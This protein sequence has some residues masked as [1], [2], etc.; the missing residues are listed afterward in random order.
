M[1]DSRGE[2]V[3]DHERANQIRSRRLASFAA[4]IGAISAAILC[5]GRNAE[6]STT[7]TVDTTADVFVV[8]GSC[9]LREAISAANSDSAVDSC[10]A[11]GGA[12]T[13]VLPAGVYALGIPGPNEDANASGDL[14][15]T[16]DLTISGSGAGTTIIDGAHLDRVVHVV[17]QAAE[18]IVEISD[19]TI[20]GGLAPVQGLLSRG[21]GILNSGTLTVTGCAVRGNSGAALDTFGGGIYNDGMLLLNNS[22]VSANVIQG[23]GGSGVYNTGTGAI[24]NSTVSGNVTGAFGGGVGNVGMISIENTTISGNTAF[25]G[26]G[27]YNY[28]SGRLT[29]SSSTVTR[30][31]ALF[32]GGVSNAGDSFIVKD[33]IIAMNIAEGSGADCSLSTPMSSLGH[34]LDSDESCGFTGPGDLS[35]ADPMLGPLANNGGPTLIHA[36]LPGSPAIDAGSPDC[37]PPAIDQRGVP[38]PQSLVCDIGAYEFGPDQQ[39]SDGDGVPDNQDNCPFVF[40]P[41]QEDSD[42]NGAGDA[43]QPANDSCGAA[44]VIASIPFSETVD[45]TAATT[46]DEDQSICGCNPNSN[47]VWY[48][49]TPTTPGT[50]TID[51]FGSTYDTVLDVFTGSCGEKS[52]VTCNDDS[53]GVQSR[54]TFTTCAGGVTYLIEA[55]NFCFSGGGT[56]M[57]HVDSSPEVADRDGDGLDDCTDNCLFTPNPD[58]ADGDGDGF[59]DACDSCSGVG[60]SDSDG[61]G[62]CDEVDNCRFHF[63]PDQADGEADGIGDACD[64]CPQVLNPDQA[65]SD[66]NGVGDA[67]ALC[68]PFQD[69]D[70][71]NVCNDAD[72]C[73]FTRHP[74][75]A[76]GDGDGVGDICDN[77]PAIHNPDQSNADGDALGDACDPCPNDPTN[78]DADGD[79]VCGNAD[80]CRFVFNPDQAD[81]DFN[82]VGDACALCPPFLDNDGDNVCNGVDNCSF[83]RNPDQADSDGDGFGDACDFCSGVGQ[84]DSD[85]DGV[86]DEVD[87]CRFRFNPDQSDGE[88]DGIG[89]ACDNC[90]AVPNPDQADSD[91]NGVGDACS[92]G[93]PVA[94]AGSDRSTE[95]ASPSGSSAT[96]DGSAS[97]DPD[98]DTLSYQW[99]GAFPEGGGTVSG[100]RPTVTLPIGPNLI[101]MTVNDGHGHATTDSVVIT[102]VDTTPP[103]V[104][105]TAAQAELWP[106]NHRMVDV[107]V[108]L[109]ASDICGTPLLMLMSVTS[110]EPDDAPGGGDGNTTGDIQGASIGTPDTMLMLRAERA[111]DSPGRFYTLTY[112]AMD[113]SGNMSSALELVTV[114][115]DLGTGPEPVIL[116]LEEDR[117]PGMAQ[118]HWNAV[119]GAEMYDVIQGEVSQVAQSNG[120]I[121]LGLVHVLAT[122]QSGTSYSEGSNGALPPPGKAFFYLVQYRDTQ[123]AS[124]WGTESSSWPAE[125]VSCD[126]ACP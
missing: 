8:D 93:P 46:G 16:S 19:L 35:G 59:G 53:S 49:F 116:S 73:P 25:S 126:I 64:N 85:G 104:T 107:E 30:N 102:V 50:V 119:P 121:S 5:L 56:L 92:N 48:A 29:L 117:T 65:D 82:G 113:A 71:D 11:G 115:H 60:R 91:F 125:P 15:I 106:P 33:T 3:T 66:F 44:T 90:P 99:I 68:P 14:D 118:L 75:Q 6:A 86:C 69:S 57:L 31:K 77:C 94:N 83:T 45:T 28:I 84:S 105:A 1:T 22:T 120:K 72:N 54:Q 124:G 95:C 58:Q 81:S 78:D 2:N 21:G 18:G 70:G 101:V 79:G 4:L 98:G 111:G 40:N 89:D 23:S 38:R 87:N 96:L 34:N 122:G 20:Q 61:D 41:G 27:I 17:P 123:S 62:V 12:D 109:S 88:G 39:D 108:G 37:P 36:L 47:S 114:P 80:N 103:V 43:C 32:G 26:G 67:C 24:R 100:V 55:S 52:F 63:N 112:V 51:T 7:I 76:D 13:I 9:S 110:S 10:P 74:D 97:S 42:G